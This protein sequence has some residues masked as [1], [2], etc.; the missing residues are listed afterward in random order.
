QAYHSSSCVNVCCISM[1][2][3]FRCF[4]LS[5][6]CRLTPTP[7]SSTRYYYSE[8]FW[9]RANGG[10]RNVKATRAF[11]FNEILFDCRSKFT[12]INHLSFRT[13]AFRE[14]SDDR[15]SKR[16]SCIEYGIEAISKLNFP[17]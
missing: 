12:S 2:C 7:T 1:E 16:I 14:G 9:W 8:H 5:E 15:L 3:L 4:N 6:I 11:Q 10:I 17:K 13:K